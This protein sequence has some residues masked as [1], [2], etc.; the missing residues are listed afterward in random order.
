MLTDAE[1]AAELA[2]ILKLATKKDKDRAIE[3][4]IQVY[5]IDMTGVTSIEFE[6]RL[7]DERGKATPDEQIG[8]GW[9]AFSDSPG[10]LGALI[11]HEAEVHIRQFKENGAYPTQRARRTTK[12]RRTSL[13]SILLRDSPPPPMRDLANPS[14]ELGR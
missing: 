12:L 5:K 6:G 7:E 4:A 1:A 3:L 14:L 2:R 10:L 13:T 11:A 9:L 8:I